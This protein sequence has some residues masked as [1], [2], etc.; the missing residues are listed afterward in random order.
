MMAEYS[1]GL[2][3]VIAGESAISRIDFDSNKLIVRG[4]DLVD[5][6]H[7]VSFEEV[8]WL[9]LYGDLPNQTQLDEL[10]TTL[11]AE[12]ELPPQALTILREAPST[13]HPMALMRSAVSALG[14]TDP[15]AGE[16]SKEASLR[17]AVRLLAKAP[18]IIA[19]GHRYSQGLEP[20]APEA[21]LSHAENLL[22]MML[23]EKP[24]PSATAAMNV[25][26]ILYT[27]HGFNASTFAARVV[28]STLADLHASITAGIAALAGPLHG[29]ANEAAMKMFIDIG[30][31]EKAHE[32]VV[33]MLAR[34]QKIMG[35]GHREYK[36]GDS[37][38]P[39]MKAVGR[40]L[41]EESGETK[42][43]DIADAVEAALVAEKGIYPNVDAPCAYA[44]Y[45]LGI[46]IPLFTPIFV[47]SRITGWAAHIIEQQENNRILRPN[48]IYTG[49]EGKTFRP[50]AER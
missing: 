31:P 24:T 16:I 18:T 1:P 29:G 35:F 20:L 36:S 15:E 49:P 46:P 6:T 4:Y 32:Y 50:L 17:K 39:S 5:L 34:K 22:Y 10:N 26:L 42:W 3:G 37:R 27:E 25:S 43:A 38:V 12:R 7:K 45:T 8:A 11:K 14:I 19:T 30:S 47:A 41:A 28:A 40:R 9:L 21:E 33:D 48:H 2:A 23:G 44:Y 13:A